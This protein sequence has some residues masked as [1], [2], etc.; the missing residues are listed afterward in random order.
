MNSTGRKL[1]GQTHYVRFQM[2]DGT[3]RYSE[4]GS[5]QVAWL[6]VQKASAGETAMVD[7]NEYG[8]AEKTVY[9]RIAREDGTWFATR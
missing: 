5:K 4:P 7:V 1:E 2:K 6:E 3:V 8:G 9:R